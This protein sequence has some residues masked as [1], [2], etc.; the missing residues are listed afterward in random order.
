MN[1]PKD[2]NSIDKVIHQ[3]MTPKA[4]DASSSANADDSAGAEME[5][6]NKIILGSPKD[7]DGAKDDPVNNILK[8]ENHD[9]TL[10]GPPAVVKDIVAEIIAGE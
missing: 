10:S 2:R 1:Q 7:A 9:A 4:P 6:V 8:G 5:F 3:G